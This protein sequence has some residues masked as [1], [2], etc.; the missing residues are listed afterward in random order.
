MIVMNKKE[1]ERALTESGGDF[2]CVS[3]T[4]EISR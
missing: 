4:C 3:N 1:K 2:E